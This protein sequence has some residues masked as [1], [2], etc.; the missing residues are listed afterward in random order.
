MAAAAAVLNN[1]NASQDQIDQ[2]AAGL[3]S[4]A[5]GLEVK[6]EEA[7]KPAVPALKKGQILTYKGLKYKVTNPT[8]GKATVMVVGAASKSVKKVTVPSEVTLRG[9]KCK[10]TKIGPKSFKNYKRLQQVI[11]GTNVTAI[12]K[13]AFYGDSKLTGIKVKSKVLEKAYS[14]CLK[15]ISSRA[16]IRV[17]GNKLN[18]YK[19]IFKNRGQKSS[20]RIK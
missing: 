1:P 20:V 18:E 14:N 13:Q 4:A 7:P 8:A 15:K 6:P 11:I 5:A 2:A 16:V 19:K 3:M 12:G 9:V 10:V 17:P